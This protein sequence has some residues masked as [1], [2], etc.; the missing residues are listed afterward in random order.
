MCLKAFRLAREEKEK[1]KMQE[2]SRR[3]EYLGSN[4]IECKPQIELMVTTYSLLFPKKQHPSGL[5]QEEPSLLC[6]RGVP[7]EG[8]T[9][10]EIPV[11]PLS[12]KPNIAG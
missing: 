4:N 8:R 3:L 6:E 11:S 5:Q 10:D 9:M 2:S 12:A 1:Q 7:S